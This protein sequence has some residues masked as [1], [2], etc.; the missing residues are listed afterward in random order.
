MWRVLA[1]IYFFVLSVSH[2]KFAFFE[3]RGVEVCLNKQNYAQRTKLFTLQVKT[4]LYG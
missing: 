3:R 2:S 1:I 4:G